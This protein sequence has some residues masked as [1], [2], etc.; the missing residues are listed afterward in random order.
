MHLER[1]FLVVNVETGKLINALDELDIVVHR[2][3]LCACIGQSSEPASERSV[4]QEN[5]G[6]TVAL[7][8]AFGTK[9]ICTIA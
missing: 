1:H 5:A 3:E 6:R 4:L 7:L 8:R 2:A 9:L